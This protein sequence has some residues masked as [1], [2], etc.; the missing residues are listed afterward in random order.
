[1]Q[2]D[3]D[4]NILH[5]GA[6]AL[7][8]S[9]DAPELT[10]QNFKVFVG[11]KD[12]TFQT[13]TAQEN[14][15][16]DKLALL[17]LT[18]LRT[19]IEEHYF[20]G[21]K[22]S[23]EKNLSC[24]IGCPSDWNEVRKRKLKSIAQEAGFPNV[25]TCD[26]AIG[27]IYYHYFFGGLKFK[28][29]QNILVYDFG[30]GTTDVAIAQVDISDN[31]EIKPSVL[32]VSGLPNLGGSNFDEALFSYY[33]NENHYD[34]NAL[35]TKDR[36]HDKW[37]IGLFAREAKEELSV[38]N[39]VEKNISRLKVSGGTKPQKFS[40]SR[41]KFMTVCSELI[42]KFDEPIYDA[43]TY[44]GLST[45]D[46][47]FVI[48]AGGS[49]AMPYVMEKMSEIFSANK[50][51]RTSSAEIIAQGLAASGKV[52]RFEEVRHENE[53][54]SISSPSVKPQNERMVKQVPVQ[55]KAGKKKILTLIASVAAVAVIA[56]GVL[57]F[58]VIRP[59]N[60]YKNAV[61]L[62]DSGRYSEAVELFKELDGYKDSAEQI[63]KISEVL[64]P[65]SKYNEAIALKNSGKY[66]EA[67]VV[68]KGLNDYKDSQNQ[69]EKIEHFLS[70]RNAAVGDFVTFGRYEQDNDDSNGKENIE[71]LVLAKE[72]DRLLLISRYAL[73][74]RPYNDTLK[75]I[76]WE[77]CTL[78][79]WLNDTFINTAFS[80]SEKA[81][82]LTVK[83]NADKNLNYISINPGNATQDKIFLLS[84]SEALH[85]FKS[86]SDRQCE[87][88]AVESSRIWWWLRSPGNV[89]ND[90][91]CVSS[92]GKISYTGAYVSYDYG[93]AVR[94]ALW[95]NISTPQ[96]ENAVDL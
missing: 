32:A 95:L 87:R 8:K 92:S 46:I 53:H 26:E 74:R 34:F 19:L 56:G 15:T 17:F 69:L 9:G 80:D 33:L 39:S 11:S 37:V 61:V 27:V 12:K 44:A 81:K 68:F 22:L 25:K 6:K 35:S 71:W 59:E 65:E 73:D 29:S 70:L 13:Y 38:K 14:Y 18:Q 62:K 42:E 10:F 45:D 57:Y 77:D 54:E 20:N 78:R 24:I 64:I 28:K 36:L 76:T 93:C 16:P 72:N 23:D 49:S 58:S 51:F 2:L 48:L 96:N 66:E 82:I 84:I 7:Q 52:Q 21:V 60:S 85:Y 94:P 4:G 1:M 63:K 40:L 55:L 67:V 89:G 3:E 41:D 50:I 5:F 30:G 75:Y 91:A 43:L 90:A 47:D 86:D 83:V 31:G 88:T 79:H